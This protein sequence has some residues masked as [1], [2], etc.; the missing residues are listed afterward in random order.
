VCNT[1]TAQTITGLFVNEERNEFVIIRNDTI[2]FRIY[3]D[4]AFAT[5]TIGE[6]VVK[7]KGKGK[8]IVEPST[9]LIEKT[10]V[11][12]RRPRNDDRLSIQILGQDSLSLELPFVQIKISR[13]QD[14][15][16]YITAYSDEKGQLFLDEKQIDYLDQKDVLIYVSQIGHTAMEQKILLEKGYDYIIQSRVPAQLSGGITR[17][18][19]WEIRQL[20][21]GEISISNGKD[22]AIRLK[23]ITNDF[24]YFDF[25]FDKNVK[26]FPPFEN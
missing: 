8:Y 20:N 15:R 18:N 6:G 14:K 12:Y 5:F 19:N 21:E 25:P 23:K 26:Q 24:P 2:Q 10:S 17:S 9:L 11:L 16:P 22:T 7:N 4:D 1:I 13:L 3:N